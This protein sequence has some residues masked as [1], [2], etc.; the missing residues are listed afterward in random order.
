MRERY[1]PGRLRLASFLRLLSGLALLVLAAAVFWRPL[2]LVIGPEVPSSVEQLALPRLLRP[3]AAKG[4]MVRVVSEPQGAR[5]SIDGSARGTTPLFAN[6][7][8]EEAQEVAVVVEK[9]NHP[10]WRRVVPCRLGGELTIRA[11]LEESR[12]A[13]GD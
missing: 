9:E 10:R 2:T 6:V 12:A 8:C 5:V 13:A 1:S 4:F 3:A 11:R 7:A